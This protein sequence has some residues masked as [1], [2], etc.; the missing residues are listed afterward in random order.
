[1]GKKLRDRNRVKAAATER[2]AEISRRLWPFAGLF[3]AVLVFYWTPLTSG[4]ASIL[5]DAVDVHYSSQKYFADNLLSGKLP[6][7][8][9]YI[10]SGFPF[11]ADPQVGAWY[12]LNWP[13]FLAGIT[14]RTIE[15]ELALHALLAAV[16]AYLL[17]L[18]LLEDRA[19]AFAAALL[20]AFSGFFAGHSSH[21][22]MFQAAA[23][24][25]WLLLGFLRAAAVPSAANIAL[26]AVSGA[27]LGLA[28]HF[29]TALYSFSALAI[30]AV[31]WIARDVRSWRPAAAVFAAIVLLSAAL[32]AVVIVP[33]LELTAHSIRANAD[34]ARSSDGALDPRALG[35]LVVPNLFGAV[36]GAYTGP[37]DVTQH[38][39]YGGLLLLPLA[40]LG[41]RSPKARWAGALLI[42]PALWYAL[43]PSWGLYRV[44]GL[45]AGFRSVRAPVHAWFVVALGLALLAGAGLLVARTR[46]RNFA[47]VA[48]AVIFADLF[49][50]NS[51]TNQLA[52]ARV[53]FDDLYGRAEQ[54]LGNAAAQQ[55]PLT[56]FLAPDKV[57]A[58]GP[59][60]GPLDVRLEATYGYNPLE[61]KAYAGYRSAAAGNDHL[62]AGLNASRRLNMQ[63]GNVDP[64]PG[65]PRVWF[66]R[67]L[68][69]A[70]GER[71]SLRL[72]AGSEP[73]ETAVVLSPALGLKQ[74]PGAAATLAADGEQGARIRY[75]SSS[76]ALLRI[77]IPYYP[78]WRATVKGI[79]LDIVRADHA[80]LGV[81]VPP[82]DNELL[83]SFRPT[84]FASS[85]AVSLVTAA[86]I[87]AMLFWRRLRPLTDSAPGQTSAA[88]HL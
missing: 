17:A 36:S 5:W 88:H 3:L 60:N 59:M 8:T 45:L 6:F 63:T 10:F 70:A 85:A 23:W 61:L 43:G 78:G 46:W 18:R 7:W 49:Y 50:W 66:P 26:A 74:D 32:A 9:P 24:L 51:A 76:K 52:Y 22:G 54:M 55:P 35:T 31:A 38:Y 57:S 14:P 81:V 83:L 67:Q 20:Y 62:L 28:G 33:G 79:P 29:Q 86:V 82:G 37:G 44:V 16:G 34:T 75:R 80:F 11:L 40:V 58:L 69:Y 30:V 56:R 84:W 65:L 1:M 13:F 15:W 73:P 25:P 19:A 53:S 21:V 68:V 2:H 42:I 48:I 41:L 4:S 71:E 39:F 87:L 77:A 64:Y 72:L 12:P 47:W 27:C